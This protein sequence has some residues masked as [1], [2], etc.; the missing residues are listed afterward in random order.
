MKKSEALQQRK[1]LIS[2]LRELT[3]AA[4]MARYGRLEN[5]EFIEHSLKKV[6]K[7]NEI[8]QLLFGESDLHILGI[9]WGLIKKTRKLK[10]NS[11]PLNPKA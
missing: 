11:N 7:E 5:L 6:K 10:R 8:I 3:E 1:E 9:R 4:I 2:L